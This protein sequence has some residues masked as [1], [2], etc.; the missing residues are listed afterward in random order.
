MS[1]HVGPLCEGLRRGASRPEDTCS[2]LSGSSGAPW[3]RVL[4]SSCPLPRPHLPPPAFQRCWKSCESPTLPTRFH[5]STPCAGKSFPLGRLPDIRE[6][7]VTPSFVTTLLALFL[8]LDHVVWQLLPY[9]HFS[10]AKSWEPWSNQWLCLLS[11]LQP[12]K[13]ASLVSTAEVELHFY[14]FFLHPLCYHRSPS[15]QPLPWEDLLIV[16]LLPGLSPTILAAPSSQHGLL[17]ASVKIMLQ[18]HQ[19]LPLCS[20]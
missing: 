2:G 13:S 14:L 20:G 16:Y 18:T 6:A 8:C 5:V 11:P 17:K 10:P 3:W 15:H 9:I 7:A 4:R 12:S 19:W 1:Q